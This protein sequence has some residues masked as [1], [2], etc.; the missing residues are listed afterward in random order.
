MERPGRPPGMQS[1]TAV[2]LRG[3]RRRAV[4]LLGMAASAT[5][6]LVGIA[7]LLY[8]GYVAAITTDDGNTPYDLPGYLF[9]IVGLAVMGGGGKLGQFVIGA[10]E[11]DTHDPL[12]DAFVAFLALGALAVLAGAVAVAVAVL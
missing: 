11:T 1:A 5:I 6:I 3:V 12:D 8:G 7:S 2:Y 9:C 4:A 10:F